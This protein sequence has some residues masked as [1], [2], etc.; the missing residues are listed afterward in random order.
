MT[1]PTDLV[2]RLSMRLPE[3]RPEAPM[4]TVCSGVR[5]VGE[6]NTGLTGPDMREESALKI[7]LRVKTDDCLMRVSLKIHLIFVM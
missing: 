5:P 7:S 4:P 6:A 1:L 2:M 3:L